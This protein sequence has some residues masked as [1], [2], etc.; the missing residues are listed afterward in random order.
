MADAYYMYILNS[1]GSWRPFTWRMIICGLSIINMCYMPNKRRTLHA[2]KNRRR[3]VMLN[4]MHNDAMISFHCTS[5]RKGGLRRSGPSLVF[6]DIWYQFNISFYSIGTVPAISDRK[7]LKSVGILHVLYIKINTGNGKTMIPQRNQYLQL[8]ET[9]VLLQCTCEQNIFL[10]YYSKLTKSIMNGIIQILFNNTT[11]EI[12]G[13]DHCIWQQ[14]QLPR[15][16][17]NA[18]LLPKRFSRLHNLRSPLSTLEDH[19]LLKLAATIFFFNCIN[20]IMNGIN[21]LYWKFMKSIA[22][23]SSMKFR[24]QTDNLWNSINFSCS[25]VTLMT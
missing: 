23:P 9:A 19:L 15:Q 20:P 14:K 4:H 16:P 10:L 21:M 7:L 17:T 3:K 11:N 18:A 22:V 24:Y 5:C 12:K 8:L 25:C 6:S 13:G 2:R 1:L